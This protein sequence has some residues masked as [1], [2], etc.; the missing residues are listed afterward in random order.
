MVVIFRASPFFLITTFERQ[1]ALL[2]KL[3]P[4][5]EKA[6]RGF[7][8][9][10]VFLCSASALVIGHRPYKHLGVREDGEGASGGLGEREHTHGLPGRG[11]L[12]PEAP[13][14]PPPRLR[15]PPLPLHVSSRP[16]AG[17][18]PSPTRP[19]TSCATTT[20]RC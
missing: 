17:W 14:H 3:F 2:L 15:S 19:R 9:G 7:L 12:L 5:A 10:L 13:P 8:L 6:V 1:P 20:W 18:R 4:L 16:R 11:R